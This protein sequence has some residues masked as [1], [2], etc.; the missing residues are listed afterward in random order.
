MKFPFSVLSL[1]LNFKMDEII[2]TQ[3]M[4]GVCSL[5]RKVLLILQISNVSN[6]Q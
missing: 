5:D 3:T 2:E 1:H 4:K 6:N